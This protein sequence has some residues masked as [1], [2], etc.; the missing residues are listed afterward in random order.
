MN[1]LENLRRRAAELQKKIVFP[2]TNDERTLKA[3]NIIKEQRIA[4]PLLT[5]NRK[6]AEETARKA[7]VSLAG[8]EFIEVEENPYNKELVFAFY[9]ARRE[10]GVGFHQAG[11][12]MKD[13]L[14]LSAMLVKQGYADG[15]VA[16]AMNTTSAVLR[17]SLTTIR[18]RK[19]ISVVSG[20]FIMVF[21][22]VRF[23]DEGT[24]LFADCGVTPDPDE[25]QL[26]EIALS[27]AET[28][29][30]LIGKPPR[31]AFLSFSTKGSARHQLA[32]KVISATEMTRSRNPD[33]VV[34]GELQLD[35]AIM[36]S[37]ARSK[38]PNSPVQGRANILIFPD[39]N[40]GNIGYKMAQR[41]AGAEAIGPILQG[42]AK[43]VNDLS[44]GC[45]VDD[46]VTIAAVTA[47][48]TLS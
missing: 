32:D 34:D 47:L 10:K 25:K 33:L 24:M 21:P 18:A 15:M 30:N 28:Y 16:G 31:I 8:T 22:D 43:P 38:A 2:E 17:A 36:P 46:I 1:T 11:N 42:M 41:M 39:L 48:Q 5:G 7:G 29:Q 44:R 45:S 27:S 6:E 14:L 23:G 35:A 37:T 9:E 13:P 20:C 40:A 4:Q 19:G 26:A 12:M 3:V